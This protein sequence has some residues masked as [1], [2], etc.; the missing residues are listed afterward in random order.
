MEYNEQFKKMDFKMPK[1]DFNKIK[2][3]PKLIIFILLI[4]LIPFS[5]YTVDANEQGVI[6]RLG[7][8]HT[9][10]EPGLHFKIPL[11][12]QVKLVKVH[13][14]HKLEFGFRT[15]DPNVQTEYKTKG[16]ENESWMLTGDKNIAEVK[17]IVQYKISDP[18]KYLFNIRNVENTIMDVS[19]SIMRGLIGDRSFEEVIKTERTNIKDAAKIEMQQRLNYYKSGINIELVQLQGVVPPL[20]VADSFR[21]VNRAEQ[22]KETLENNA[23]KMREK[24]IGEAEGRAQI[25]EKNAEAYEAK[26]INEANGQASAFK[27][28]LNQ[29]NGKDKKGRSVKNIV[30]YRM[31]LETMEHVLS[32]NSNLMIIDEGIDN[33]VPFLEQRINVK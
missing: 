16:Y 13:F 15:V 11:V 7:K 33:L 27:A 28:I 22:E 20:P 6:L 1:F 25:L 26:R 8:Y 21:E 24:V 12:D 18:Q 17:W 2:I 4:G 30:M 19:E 3:N 31:Y 32:N 14:Q 9:T 5:F 10:T 29:L 23:N